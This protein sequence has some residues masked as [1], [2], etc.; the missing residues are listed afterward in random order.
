[1]R[2][3]V[4]ITSAKLL[5][6]KIFHRNQVKPQVLVAGEQSAVETI[7]S[8][9]G[10][11]SNK[12]KIDKIFENDRENMFK[13]S[14]EWST[15]GTIRNE[16]GEKLKVNKLSKNNGKISCEYQESRGC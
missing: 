15:V 13:A 11:S 12:I 8:V 3:T 7:K 9:P 6:F 1:V 10:K 2:F 4:H 14:G 16:Q 5:H